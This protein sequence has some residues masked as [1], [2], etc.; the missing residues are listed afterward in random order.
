MR[1]GGG[2]LY[3]RVSTGNGNT[4]KEPIGLYKEWLRLWE[5]IG[6]HIGWQSEKGAHWPPDGLT[7]PIGNPLVTIWNGSPHQRVLV[8][9]RERKPL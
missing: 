2:G 3:R 6:P 7:A 8:S 9:H 5:V 1:I 4:C